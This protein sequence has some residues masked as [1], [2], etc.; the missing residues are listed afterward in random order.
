M[1]LTP[2]LAKRAARAANLKLVGIVKAARAD[3]ALVKR[4]KRDVED[5]FYDIGQALAR[6]KAP[7]VVRAL[8]YT[9]F[10][11]L[12]TKEL[13]ISASQAERL[14]TVVR[15]MDR[16]AAG[17]L[18]STKAAALLDLVEATPARDTAG[19]VLRRGV[20]LPGGER[21]DAKRASARA[22]ERAAKSI[23]ATN[24]KRDKR[25]RH[26]DDDSRAL[27]AALEKK[28]HSL[29]AKNAKVTV[30]AGAPGKPANVRIEHV[31]VTEL[32]KLVK[33]VAAILR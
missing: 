4:R 6:L 15:G 13:Q 31:A 3:I 25:G 11:E 28:L 20:A 21:L 7:V 12:C 24:A 22:I 30:L 32:S 1:A 33:A 18:G 10:A 23:R 29:G 27:G 5:A 8:G 9:S 19:G 17:K 16:E 14:I 2:A 26:L